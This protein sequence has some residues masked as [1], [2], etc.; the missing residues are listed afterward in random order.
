[1]STDP[2]ALPRRL[3]KRVAERLGIP[4][5][6]AGLLWETGRVRVITPES[7]EPRSFPLETLVFEDDAVLLDGALLEAAPPLA[8]ALLNK[9]KHVTSTTRDPRDKQNL[10]P[11]LHVMPRGCFPVGRLDRE[12]TG[13]LLCT[14]DGDLASAVL[15]PDHLTTKTYWL[16][17]DDVV[18]DDDPR[19]TQFL[20]GVPHNGQHLAAKSARILAR[21]QHSTELELVLT[22]GR[23]RQIRLMCRILGLHLQH[24]HRSRIGPLTDAGL[25][26]GTWR[27]LTSAEVEDLWHA[28]GGR[29]EVRRRQLAALAHQATDLRTAGTPHVRLEHWLAAHAEDRGIGA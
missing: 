19:L 28:A 21:S 24:L 29:A 2:P 6:D 3:H 20:G 14:N 4:L 26:L 22:Q 5:Q 1:M 16:W 23:K 17:L 9:P 18:S 13:I 7:D 8:Y 25:A 12:T 27:S 11:Y 15:R 10:A